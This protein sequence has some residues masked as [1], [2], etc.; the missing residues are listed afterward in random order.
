MVPIVLNIVML[1][2]FLLT[3]PD[4]QQDTADSPSLMLTGLPAR[5]RSR[6][7]L[8]SHY[9]QAGFRVTDVV[10][11]PEIRR[12]QELDD[13]LETVQEAL[14]QIRRQ[15]ASLNEEEQHLRQSVRIGGF[16]GL[17]RGTW[18]DAEEDLENREESLQDQLLLEV[19]RI[20]D[21]SVSDAVAFVTFSSY[22]EA[23]KAHS[24]GD[25]E[26]DSQAAPPT[27]DL[28]Y[29]NVPEKYS[30]LWHYVRAIL[31]YVVTF[32][33]IL[34]IPGILSSEVL[35][36]LGWQKNLSEYPVATLM[37]T[38]VTLVV[39]LLPGFL[40]NVFPFHLLKSNRDFGILTII[41]IS[42]A[43]SELVL[44]VLSFPGD[45]THQFF[46]WLVN[47]SDQVKR[48][49]CSFRPALSGRFGSAIVGLTFIRCFMIV[50]RVDLIVPFL[51]NL[52]SRY[53]V[54][55]KTKEE[56]QVIWNR[57][58]A[59]D[60]DFGIRYAELIVHLCLTMVAII[61]SPLNTFPSLVSII[62]RYTTDWFS[63]TTNS[64]SQT[65]HAAG[66]IGPLLAFVLS[67]SILL[68]FNLWR[69]ASAQ[70][71]VSPISTTV[72]WAS[73]AITLG[74]FLIDAGYGVYAACTE[75]PD[76]GSKDDRNEKVD[77]LPL[78]V[79]KHLLPIQGLTVKV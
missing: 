60:F 58:P 18:L 15:S 27:T 53:A 37:R 4:I 56:C 36:H 55:T 47:I 52:W 50:V 65:I 34:F 30:Q 38:I 61:L 13:E 14:K 54:R 44:P 35:Y 72:A 11:L 29:R 2:I 22:E 8:Q 69:N 20:S 1:V 19:A 10:L 21:L 7:A 77:F 25:N 78:V 49:K 71:I 33:A 59:A 5:M 68:I 17:F 28:I 9:E 24:Q 67:A 70:Y 6:A 57:I 79:K 43:V 51:K 63:F 12:L 40:E 62:V 46:Y 48:I 75:G 3:R 64:K 41:V 45:I 42:Q 31:S 26:W 23:R 76:D 74:A 32:A 66:R 16:M 73:F 39:S